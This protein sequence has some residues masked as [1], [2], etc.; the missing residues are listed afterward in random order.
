MTCRELV[1]FLNDYVDGDLP[2]EQRQRFDE[3]LG[4]CPECRRYLDSYEKTIR[5]SKSAAIDEVEIPEKLVQAI[6]AAK[7]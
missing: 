3:H 4:I 6:L 2:S 5:A 7:K 1:E